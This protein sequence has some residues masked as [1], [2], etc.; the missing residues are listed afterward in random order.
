MKIEKIPLDKLLAHPANANVMKGEYL[1]KLRRHIEK[2]GYYEPLVVRPH[3]SK[4]N[5][6]ELLN[7]HHRKCVLEQLESTH[8]DCVVWQVNDEQALLLL[9]TLNRLC[10]QDDPYKRAELLEKLSQRFEK[11]DLVRQLPEK[12]Q[13]LEKVLACRK[14]PEVLEPEA[15]PEMPQ[16]LTFFVMGEQKAIIETSLQKVRDE[17]GGDDPGRKLTKGDLLAVLAEQYVKEGK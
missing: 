5:W 10:G 1:K 9:A 6:Y 13:Q 7:G 4:E 14:S 16:V 8:A 17:V 11:D 15:L 3:P 2:Q 12:R